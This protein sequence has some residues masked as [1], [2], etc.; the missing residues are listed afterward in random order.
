MKSITNQSLFELKSV[1]NPKQVANEIYFIETSM[2]A[3]QNDYFS[4][5]KSINMQTQQIKNWSPT[6]VSVQNFEL[7]PN[8]HYL[9]YL[10]KIAGNDTTQLFIMSLNGGAAEQVTFA[11][12]SVI[13]YKWSPNSKQLFY[14]TKKAQDKGNDVSTDKQPQ[15]HQTKKI[16]YKADGAG[17]LPSDETY[18]LKKLVLSSKEITEM[19]TT[20]HALAMAYVNYDASQIVINESKMIDDEFAF[21]KGTVKVLDVASTTLSELEAVASF[22]TIS[23]LA[24]SPSGQKYLLSGHDFRYGFVTVADLYVYDTLTKSLTC[25][26]NTIDFEEGDSLV[27]DFQQAVQG[28]EVKWLDESSFVFSAT[29]TGAVNL[30]KGTIFGEIE[31]LFANHL[32]ITSGQYLVNEAVIT[33]S[34]PTIPSRLAKINQQGELVDI[35]NPNEIFEQATT[36]IEPERFVYK[37][38]DHWNIQGWYL[39]PTHYTK[40]Y[41]AILYIHGGPQVAYGET[42]FHEMQV[43]AQL[44]YGVIMLNPR[45][46]SS[47]GQKFVASILGAYGQHDYDDLMMGVD[48]VLAQHPE[49]D[50]ESLYVAGGSY[51]GFMTNWIVGHTNRFK[52]AVTQRSIS[53]W[54]SFYGTSDIGVF[55]VENQLKHSL[56]AFDVLWQMS[57]LAYAQNVKT[58]TLILHGESDL[59]CPQEQAEQFYIALKKFGVETELM[60][61][62]KSS[63]GLSRMGLPNLRLARLE[64]IQN[65]FK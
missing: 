10:A 1:A 58:P 15:P 63:H 34:T 4:V 44:G 42:F 59:R 39:K 7:S 33:Y 35:Y 48:Y 22:E 49:I 45:G 50:H 28:F 54:I 14:Q 26:S 37:G 31:P 61:F 12:E 36:I 24:A 32:H 17:L 43:L 23:F 11:K 20:D 8:H 57:P 13:S 30:Y 51:G 56:E 2:R 55:F 64:A 19:M 52:K 6:N 40:Q 25:V 47:Y 5:I 38:Y 46:S 29:V 62:P 60:T 21:A 41:P 53:N 16:A 65:W 18:V 9:S 27:A 3:K